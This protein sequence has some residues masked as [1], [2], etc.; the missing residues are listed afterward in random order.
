MRLFNS[1]VN[2]FKAKYP[3][4]ESVD[5]TA[6]YRLEEFKAKQEAITAEQ[7]RDKDLLGFKGD[8]HYAIEAR[9][10]YGVKTLVDEFKRNFDPIPWDHIGAPEGGGVPI[11]NFV[12]RMPCTPAL[13]SIAEYLVVFGA[14]REAKDPWSDLSP[15]D[16]AAS[17][18]SAGLN[19]DGKLRPCAEKLLNVLAPSDTPE[20]KERDIYAA[21]EGHMRSLGKSFRKG[22]RS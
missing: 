18:G 2:W 8:L 10:F 14:S 15:L 16:I 20:E 21:L 22:C 17:S 11:L 19:G 3:I 1:L 13:S 9:D 12:A 4:E 7:K 5:K 6:A